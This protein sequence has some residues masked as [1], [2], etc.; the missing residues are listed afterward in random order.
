M[1]GLSAEQY[2]GYL[3]DGKRAEDFETLVRE[4]VRGVAGHPA[5][6]CYAIGNEIPGPTVR[7]LGARPIER[8]LEYLCRAI[9]LEDPDGL[10]TY[11]NYPTTEYLRLPFLDL[12]CFNV[13][14]EAPD[15]FD[16]YLAR[17]HNLAGD[18]P[19]IMSEIGLDALRN[20]EDRQAEVLDWQVRLTFAAGCAGAF[21]FSWTDEWWRGGAEVKDWA[22]GLTDQTRQ[23]KR[24]LAAVRAAFSEVPFPEHEAWPRISVVVCSYNGSGTIRDCCAGLLQLEYPDFEVIVVDDGS[25]D[26]TASIAREYGFRVISTDNCGLS[27][28]RNTGLAA[29]T[30]EIVAY[31]DDD[32]W[33]DPDWLKYLAATFRCEEFVGVGGPNLPPPGDGPIAACVANAPG[34]PLH[35]LL[36]DREAEHIPGCNMAF[37]KSALEAIGGFD[38]QF[39]TAGDDVDICWQLQERGG[40]IGFHP[41]AVVWH[42]RRN[43]VRAYLRQQVG[44]GKAEALLERKWPEKYNAAGHVRWAGRIYGKGVTHLLS[45]RR[46]RIYHGIWGT[47]PFQSSEEPPLGLLSSIPSMP[48]WHLV[49]AGLAILA[50]TH[51]FGWGLSL[52]VPLLALSAGIALLHAIISA[53]RASF[54]E[55]ASSRLTD[56]GLRGLTA[57]LHLLQPLARLRGRL[58]LGLT[59]WRRISG[60]FAPPWPAAHAYWTEYWLAPEHRVK[61]LSEDLR[62]HGAVVVH[63]SDF[64]RWDL[65]VSGGALGSAR[66]LM[67][68][69]DQGAGTQFVRVRWWPRVPPA[70]FGVLGGLATL[71]IVAAV[72]R[73]WTAAVMFATVTALIGHTTVAQCGRAVAAVR[74]A[75]VRQTKIHS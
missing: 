69:E 70:L 66:L 68:V 24:A 34:G 59:P 38:P 41:A 39:R 32:A 5:I 1:V 30:G 10:V 57:G 23:E 72:G 8:Y 31:I 61:A 43:S 19:L 36:S 28:A 7:W 63:G 50:A 45:W 25:R 65:Q 33:P 14:L 22:F 52:V 48:E 47:A 74:R 75:A 73:D 27:S 62:S 46:R 44:Y 21:I 54:P 35:V 13:Y 49:V 29:A 26:G 51:W 6:L 12:L 53:S 42:H 55:R 15:R 60:E 18:R 4:K 56:L 2:V 9:K 3:L 20:G 40:R 16:A 58:R 71:A 37:R 11:V 64:D 17:L 67:A